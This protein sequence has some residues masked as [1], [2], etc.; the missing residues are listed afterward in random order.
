MG[1]MLV[2]ALFASA[3]PSYAVV[4]GDFEQ[5]SPGWGLWSGGVQPFDANYA[6]TTDGATLNQFA[7]QYTNPNG[8]GAV[9]SLAYS[10]G[11]VGTIADFQANDK[12]LFDITFPAT[13]SG[14]FA[15]IREIV[16]N[17][18]F[19]GFDARL[20]GAAGQVG[21]GDGGGGAQ[22]LTL[23]Y[24]YTNHKAAWGA[25]TPGWVEIVIQTNSD[26]AHGVFQLDNVRLARLVPE[27]TSIA[28]LA[29]VPMMLL[30]IRRRSA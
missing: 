14:G 30:G 8:S 12:F 10:A 6:Y 2:A 18:Q 26:A 5:T 13:S 24:D 3:T 9:Q 15:E 21:W 19:G 17:S 11:A 4:I 23:E 16:L 7:I 25:N 27:P 20:Q 1:L 22:T 29:F 28:L